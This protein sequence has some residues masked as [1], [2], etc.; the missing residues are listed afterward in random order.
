MEKPLGKP[1][2]FSIS[3][4]GRKTGTVVAQM[5]VIRLILALIDRQI[6]AL[7]LVTDPSERMR[8]AVDCMLGLQELERRITFRYLELRSLC[9][10][11]RFQITDSYSQGV[12]EKIHS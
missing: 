9:G 12:S 7:R 10:L 6:E 8:G 3:I 11:G 1:G 2:G 4:K 5:A